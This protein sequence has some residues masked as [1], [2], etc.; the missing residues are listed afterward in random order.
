M[1]IIESYCL[2]FSLNYPYKQEYLYIMLNN[3][4]QPVGFEL[5]TLAIAQQNWYRIVDTALP[6]PQDFC[7]PETATIIHKSKYIL[8]ATLISNS[9]D[10][11]V[12]QN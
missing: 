12:H 4:W 3:Y 11:I 9:D 6:T 7:P 5:P 8:T 1:M 10:T 2:A